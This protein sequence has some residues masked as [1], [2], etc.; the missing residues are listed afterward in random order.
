MKRRRTPAVTHP[1]D[2]LHLLRHLRP[3]QAGSA[4]DDPNYGPHPLVGP[5]RRL[6]N[7]H[8]LPSLRQQTPST[9]QVRNGRLCLSR[10]RLRAAIAV[11]NTDEDIIFALD[12]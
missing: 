11:D 1:S 8:P 12:Y 7:R 9:D 2:Q 3:R 6:E 10:R 5:R 4:N